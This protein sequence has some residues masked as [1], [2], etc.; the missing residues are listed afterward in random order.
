MGRIL[1]ED[2]K[3]EFWLAAYGVKNI[4]KGVNLVIELLPYHRP[5][6][7][8]DWCQRSSQQHQKR[9]PWFESA[10]WLSYT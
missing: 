5:W 7:C 10:I 6:Y 2:D 4:A 8:K 3:F 1:K 9:Y